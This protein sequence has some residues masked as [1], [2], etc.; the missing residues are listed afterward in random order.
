MCALASSV[1]AD[2]LRITFDNPPCAPLTDDVG[3]VVD[4]SFFAGNC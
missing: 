1:A 2:P 4:P 3:H